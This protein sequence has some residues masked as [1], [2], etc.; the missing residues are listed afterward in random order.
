M[1]EKRIL[2][3]NPLRKGVDYRQN[4]VDMGFYLNEKSQINRENENKNQIHDLVQ[5]VLKSCN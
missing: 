4:F 3:E 2:F 5:K 1:R